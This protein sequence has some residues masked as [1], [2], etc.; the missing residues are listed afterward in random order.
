MYVEPEISAVQGHE[1]FAIKGVT[2][3]DLELLVIGLT[4]MLENPEQ[5][6]KF[7]GRPSVFANVLVSWKYGRKKPVLKEEFIAAIDRCIGELDPTRK[8]GVSSYNSK[9]GSVP[10]VFESREKMQE[11]TPS[12]RLGRL[13]GW[14]GLFKKEFERLK[15]CKIP[16]TWLRRFVRDT[17]MQQEEKGYIYWE[18]GDILE[19]VYAT[20]AYLSIPPIM[21]TFDLRFDFKN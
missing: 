14:V 5:E 2:E 11:L 21:E 18:G 20:K 1:T 16:D 3:D 17:L 13:T 15:R 12:A 7:P 8:W 9:R 10:D 4:W 6:I 19:D